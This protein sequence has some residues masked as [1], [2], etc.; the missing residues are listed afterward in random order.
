MEAKAANFVRRHCET[1]LFLAIYAL[2]SLAWNV[3]GGSF[4]VWPDLWQL[5]PWPSLL[6]DLGRSLLDLHAQPPLLNLLFG[7]VLKTAVG[8]GTNVETLLQPVYFAIGAV[9]VAAIGELAKRIVPRPGVRYAVLLLI[10]L[11]PYFYAVHHYLFYTAWE[12]FFVS[13]IVFFSLRYLEQPTAPRLT[14]VLVPAVLLVYTRSLFHL[15]WFVLFLF[16]LLALGLHSTSGWWKSRVIVSAVALLL[17]AAWPLKNL[18]RFGFFGLSSWSGLSLARGL[19][20]GEPLLPS[21]Y[22]KRLALFARTNSLPIDLSAVAAAQSLVPPEFQGH[23]TLSELAKPDGSPNWNH[24]SI[25]PISR[26][27]GIA[28]REHLLR[29]PSL[30]IFR[31]I[32][33]YLNGYSIYEARWPYE[34]GFAPEMTTGHLWANIYEAIVFQKF[35]P[36]DPNRTTISTGFAIL[37]PV[38]LLAVAI[39]LWLRRPWGTVQRTIVVM[40]FIVLW[41]LGLVLFVDGPEGNRVRFCTEPYLFLMFGWLVGSCWD[42]IRSPGEGRFLRSRCSVSQTLRCLLS[43]VI[44]TRT[45]I[46]IHNPT[47][48][49]S[50]AGLQRLRSK[51][52][53]P[54]LKEFHLTCEECGGKTR[55]IHP[56]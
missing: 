31:A 40:L 44:A 2:L 28:A 35:R 3:A 46:P 15:L 36:Y 32:D 23:P 13:L 24:Y 27:L 29:E 41:V 26:D 14:A 4:R 11:N 54:M 7:L 39:V 30:L 1:I 5:L 53:S 12:L 33:F 50:G 19:P 38:I 37:L 8:M 55:Y 51:R 45:A 20:T 10:I 42:R 21:G 17:I 25:I 16:L 22:P 56:S 52:N 47:T 34:L 43:N 18:A 48:I 9:M 6:D 49:N